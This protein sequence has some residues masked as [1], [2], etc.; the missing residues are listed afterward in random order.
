ME[1]RR[2]A[3]CG[4]AFRPRS[5]VPQ[6][7]Y[8]SAPACQRERRRGWA[9]PSARAMRIIAKTRTCPASVGAQPS[10]VLARLLAHAPAVLRAQPRRCPAAATR[11]AAGCDVVGLR[12]VCK[13]GRVDDGNHFGINAIRAGGV[14]K[15]GR[16][17]GGGAAL[18]ASL[19]FPAAPPRPPSRFIHGDPQQLPPRIPASDSRRSLRDARGRPWTPWMNLRRDSWV[20]SREQRRVHSGEH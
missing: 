11:S 12:E 3:A 13:D 17:R 8:C 2:C 9:R 5:Q 4:R 18:L 15:R 1:R 10:R 7:R 19:P 20:H 6:Q 14:C 16:N